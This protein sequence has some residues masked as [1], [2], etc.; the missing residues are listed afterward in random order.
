VLI[1][2]PAISTNADHLP[3]ALLQPH[4]HD[5]GSCSLRGS[6]SFEYVGWKN[7]DHDFA[8]PLGPLSI[9]QRSN[10]EAMLPGRQVIASVL[11]PLI[12]TSFLALLQVHTHL[13]GTD[14]GR[15]GRVPHERGGATIGLETHG[16]ALRHAYCRRRLRK[17]L[18]HA[19]R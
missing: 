10:L 15:Q 11:E 17:P 8:R 9:D 14:T 3:L 4:S 2:L 19:P 13:I 5:A 1:L 7:R 12:Q 18:D 16:D 6:G